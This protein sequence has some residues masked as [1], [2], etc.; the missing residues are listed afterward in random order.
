M[1]TGK[2]GKMVKEKRNK[3]IL[4]S[5]FTSRVR[6]KILSYL[7]F[8]KQS[9]FIRQLSNALKIS[10][11]IVKRKLENLLLIGIV[12]KENNLFSLDKS[13]IFLEDLKSIFIKTDYLAGSLKKAIVSDKIQL[14]FISGSFAKGNFTN[15]SDI[16]LLVI[17]VL[18]QIDLFGLVKSAEK[19][20]N[21]TI[22]PILFEP[23]NFKK[24]LG[25]G[26]VKD[27]LNNKKIFLKG[28]ENELQQIIG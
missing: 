21:R 9:V 26:F 25:T 5:L 15:E 17:G 18:S 14:A 10:P 2:R 24:N 4:E 20:T 13:C 1:K 28:D 11:S 3:S 6:V 12:K 27:I 8:N 22:N 7:F 23:K 19:E 16:D